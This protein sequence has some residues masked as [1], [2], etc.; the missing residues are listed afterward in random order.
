MLFKF[1]LMQSIHFFRDDY[2]VSCEELD[3]LVGIATTVKGVYGARMTG[4]GF[5]GSVVALVKDGAIQ[6][7]LDQI[8]VCRDR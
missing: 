7:L 5:G 6:D 8:K 4:G 3:R 2:E 1:P